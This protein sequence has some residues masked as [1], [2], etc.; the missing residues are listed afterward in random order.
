LTSVIRRIIN[1]FHALHL[2]LVLKNKINYGVGVWD[3]CKI[4]RCFGFRWRK[5]DS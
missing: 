1:E 3:V 4:I 5:S 2:L